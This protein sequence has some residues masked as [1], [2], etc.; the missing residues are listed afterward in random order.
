MLECEGSM[1]IVFCTDNLSIFTISEFLFN[2]S[3]MCQHRS[4]LL[5]VSTLQC[6]NTI[7]A[8]LRKLRSIE[9]KVTK[10]EIKE[11]RDV[12]FIPGISC[13]FVLYPKL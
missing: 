1:R 13:F 6:G 3:S 12:F 9:K 7:H 4:M 5:I 2:T 8:M 11:M 10:S